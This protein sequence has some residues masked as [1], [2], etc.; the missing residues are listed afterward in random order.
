[1]DSPLHDTLPEDMTE[2][3]GTPATG[4]SLTHYMLKKGTDDT[5]CLF[6]GL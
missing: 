5:A 1:M 2:A 3:A 6:S 4:N